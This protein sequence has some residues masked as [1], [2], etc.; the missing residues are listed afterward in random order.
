MP[1]LPILSGAELISLLE[2]FGFV[3]VRQKGSHIV[4]KKNTSVQSIG[5]VVPNHKELAEGTLRAILRQCH[6]T[7]DEFIEKYR[8]K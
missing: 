3:Q 6:I 5:T 1:R 4:L 2:L 7:P 8:S